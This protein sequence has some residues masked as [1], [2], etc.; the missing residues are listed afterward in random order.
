[1]RRQIPKA[2]KR[3]C[4][5][6]IALVVLGAAI[7]ITALILI[8]TDWFRDK[9]RNRIIAEVEKS[10]GGRVE[11][12]SFKWHTFTAELAPFVVHGSEPP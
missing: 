12:G 9:I 6:L 2:V 11:I 10:T 3:I 8:Q 4:I 5:A 7:V 1:M